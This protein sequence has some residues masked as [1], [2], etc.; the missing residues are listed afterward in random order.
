M[1]RRTLAAWLGTAW[2]LSIVTAITATWLLVDRSAEPPGG[3]D[4]PPRTVTEPPRE[5]PPRSTPQP[6]PHERAPTPD[7]DRSA[8]ESLRARIREL[9][10]ELAA[11]RSHAPPRRM[12]EE[13]AR[14]VTLRMDRYLHER[15]KG[16]LLGGLEDALAM[17]VYLATLGDEGID[18]LI[19]LARDGGTFE[20]REM[21]LNA[22][23]FLPSQSAFDAIM[24]Y[25]WSQLPG[26][27]RKPQDAPST[28][29]L[30]QVMY[31]VEELSTAEI[32][33][34]AD[35]IATRLE[36]EFRTGVGKMTLRLCVA[37][38]LRHGDDTA[39]RLLGDYWQRATPEQKVGLSQS[40]TFV[41]TERS[42][43]FLSDTAS[44]D[45]DPKVRESAQAATRELAEILGR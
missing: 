25:D 3:M 17:M 44:R 20:E 16:V 11:A 41:E 2:I 37:M 19:G 8:N 43:R 4:P 27:D 24:T 40:L 32:R 36:K 34:H 22:L 29:D 30:D 1:E 42:L 33:A 45:L 10:S 23:A 18:L 31:H 14:S 35:K 26:E 5:P 9:E 28:W 12:D 39:N 13:T 38:A 6:R 15:K 21:A 7:P